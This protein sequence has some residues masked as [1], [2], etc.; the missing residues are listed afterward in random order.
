MKHDIKKSWFTAI[1]AL[2]LFTLILPLH[3][4]RADVRPPAIST[5]DHPVA[6]VTM[7]SASAISFAWDA[8]SGATAYQVRYVRL[9]DNYNSGTT[10]TG[11]TSITYNSLAA[12]T[13]RF[14]F[15]TVCGMGTSS[16]YVIAELVII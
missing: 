5:C 13:Y 7:Q 4:G 3:E 9:Q 16:D 14:Y 15:T 11:N 10:T 8:V 2:A 12:G 1:A 6:T